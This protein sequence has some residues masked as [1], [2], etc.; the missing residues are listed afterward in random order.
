MQMYNN[1]LQKTSVNF[2]DVVKKWKKGGQWVSGI[3]AVSSNVRFIKI[4]H[5]PHAICIDKGTP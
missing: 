2:F 3:V 5:S 1:T 4:M